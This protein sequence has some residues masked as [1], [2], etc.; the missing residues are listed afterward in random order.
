M[1]AWAVVT[2]VIDGGFS[3]VELNPPGPDQLQLVALAAEPVSVSVPPTHKDV[4]D[5]DAM[6]L[7]ARDELT[8]IDD[9]LAVAVP[10]LLIALS[11]YIPP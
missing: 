1:P 10:Q 6:G 8:D 11:V 3:A 9:E 4:E 5:T 2:F 7:A